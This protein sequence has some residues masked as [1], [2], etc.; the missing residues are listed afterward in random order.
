[1]SDGP[2][3]QHSSSALAEE[4]SGGQ[5]APL[6]LHL[7]HLAR[8]RRGGGNDARAAEAALAAYENALAESTKDAM[9]CEGD[10]AYTV[11]CRRCQRPCFQ[12]H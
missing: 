3:D 1:M 9:R 2:P 7:L 4:D 6:H 8:P 12:V 10:E 5:A 11:T